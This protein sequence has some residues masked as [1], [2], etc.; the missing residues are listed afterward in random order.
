M[1]KFEKVGEPCN[2]EMLLSTIILLYL[3]VSM[4]LWHVTGTKGEVPR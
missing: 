2:S 1:P 4:L 3:E